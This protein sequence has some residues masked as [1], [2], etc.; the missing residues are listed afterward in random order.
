MN[1][2]SEEWVID[3]ERVR[4]F[5]GKKVEIVGRG[6]WIMHVMETG[7]NGKKRPGFVQLL[8]EPYDLDAAMSIT[9]T[10]CPF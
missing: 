5:D 1:E 8:V 9:P 2:T 3:C 10:P 4:S 7:T 6:V